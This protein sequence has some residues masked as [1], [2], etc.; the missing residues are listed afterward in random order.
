MRDRFL[1]KT[2]RLSLCFHV[3]TKKSVYIVLSGSPLRS[4][5]ALARGWRGSR[6]GLVVRVCN[7][8]AA[9]LCW[10][11]SLHLWTGVSREH[12]QSCTYR[13]TVH[14][15]QTLETLQTGV[16]VF[17]KDNWLDR[18]HLMTWVFL[19]PGRVDMLR[20]KSV[21]EFRAHLSVNVKTFL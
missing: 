13:D 1:P 11:P 18:M 20:W 15:Q 7:E 17:T 16:T 21:Q 12:R 3:G 2:A 9:S 10:S 5:M 8:A 6:K 4:S 19:T 14:L